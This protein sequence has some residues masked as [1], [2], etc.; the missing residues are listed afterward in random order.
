MQLESNR[1]LSKPFIWRNHEIAMPK[2]MKEDSSIVRAPRP[3]NMIPACFRIDGMARLPTI[4]APVKNFVKLAQLQWQN[5]RIHAHQFTLQYK[6][7]NL[8]DASSPV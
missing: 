7:K 8:R 5:H 1:E 4:D 2:T 3:M 6:K